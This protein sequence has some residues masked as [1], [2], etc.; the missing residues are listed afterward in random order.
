MAFELDI[1]D[2][3]SR[4]IRVEVAPEGREI[5]DLLD[6]FEDDSGGFLGESSRLPSN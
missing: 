6:V 2:L 5:G 3:I 1:G 4:Q